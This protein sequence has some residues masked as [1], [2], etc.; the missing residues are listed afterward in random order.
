MNTEEVIEYLK[1]VKRSIDEAAG[2][3]TED[4]PY[5]IVAGI[6][7]DSM[8]YVMDCAIREL[9]AEHKTI[10]D[11]I[12]AVLEPTREKG[13]WEEDENGFVCCTN[14]RTVLTDIVEMGVYCK[15]CGAEMRG[16]EE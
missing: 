7:P 2:N 14:C 9:T 11:N 3:R 6:K 1:L 4:L 12:K 16:E 10:T 5:T 13:R 15:Y 8:K